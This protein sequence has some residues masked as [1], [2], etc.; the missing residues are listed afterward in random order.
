MGSANAFARELEGQTLTFVF[1]NGRIVD[2]ETGSEWN[3]LGQAV[4]GKLKGKSLTP[5]IAI[6]HFWFSW[7]AFKPET[8]VYKP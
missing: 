1:Q 7:A 3:I 2:K 4:N 5:V 8:K 6:N